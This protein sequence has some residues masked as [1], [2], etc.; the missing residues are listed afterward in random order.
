MSTHLSSEQISKWMAGD[1]NSDAGQHLKECPQ[2]AAEIARMQSLLSAFRSSVIE[3]NTLQGNA[4]APERWMPSQHRLRFAGN[5]MRWKLAAAMLVLI[6][7]ILVWKNHND[8]R[9]EAAAFE[10]DIRLWEEVNSHISQ[11]VPS[12]MAPLMNLVA[13][14]PDAIEKKI[15]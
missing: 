15:Q 6:L 5:M 14:E 12:P 10:A 13:W 3:W 8:R 1:N 7:G 9:R 2:C 4:K 11:P